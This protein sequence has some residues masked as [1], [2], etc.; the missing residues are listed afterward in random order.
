MNL[1]LLA[2]CSGVVGASHET[3]HQLASGLALYLKLNGIIF[4]LCQMYDHAVFGQLLDISDV[5]EI[6]K[7]GRLPVRVSNHKEVL[8]HVATLA[9]YGGVRR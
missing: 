9:Q 1:S 3:A 7:F 4:S 2:G 6:H 8:V 5:V